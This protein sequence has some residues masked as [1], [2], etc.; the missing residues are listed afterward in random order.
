MLNR[1]MKVSNR[2]GSKGLIKRRNFKIIQLF[3]KMCKILTVFVFA[4]ICFVGSVHSQTKSN[5][6]QNNQP[7]TPF[8]VVDGKEVVNNT[9]EISPADILSIA[10]LTD[11]TSLKK[12]GDK[13][14]NGILMI[15]TKHNNSEKPAAQL[16]IING[17]EGSKI[18]SI[19]F[20]EIQSISMLKK[21][22]AFAAYGEKA[23]NGVII[24][25]TRT[26]N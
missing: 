17:I 7:T 1:E 19:S 4:T 15:T 16:I 5:V 12:Y 25:K 6:S 11:Q 24:I 22:S 21:E 14:K 8:F 18:K 13:G 23:K 3:S 10:S 20:A 9:E 26:E 2:S